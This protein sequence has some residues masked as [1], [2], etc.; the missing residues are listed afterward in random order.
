M[1]TRS[2]GGDVPIHRIDRVLAFMAL[3]LVVLA[4]VS[5]AAVLLAPALGV[6]NYSEG[7]WP[8]A[9]VLPLIALPLG[10]ILIVVLLIMSFLR[11]ARANRGE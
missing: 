10:F 5:L 8:V 11:R 6:T 4:V 7:L 9:I 1:S 3:G 2:P